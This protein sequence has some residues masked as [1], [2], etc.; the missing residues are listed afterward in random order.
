MI[1]IMALQSS[2]HSRVKTITAGFS[3]MLGLV[4]HGIRAAGFT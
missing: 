1:S 2:R 4:G 3:T